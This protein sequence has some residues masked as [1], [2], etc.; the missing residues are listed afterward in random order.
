MDSEFGEHGTIDA[1]DP[2]F[3][4]IFSVTG[5]T[6]GLTYRFYSTSENL[7]G[8]S[9][10]SVEVLFAAASLVAKPAAIRRHSDT[11]RT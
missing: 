6:P 10:Q 4:G 2:A 8:E 9:D 1:T 3:T 5:L 11:S 7:I